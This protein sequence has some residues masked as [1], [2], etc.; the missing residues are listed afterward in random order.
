VG[1]QIPIE[2]WKSNSLPLY[3][4]QTKHMHRLEIGY[5]LKTK[6]IE[7]IVEAQALA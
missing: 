1:I 6:S 5:Q 2:I 7:I 3:E 4:I